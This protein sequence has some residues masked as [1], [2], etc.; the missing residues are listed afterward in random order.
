[1]KSFKQFIVETSKSKEKEDPYYYHITKGS[2]MAGIA[3]KGLVRKPGHRSYSFSKHGSVYLSSTPKSAKSFAP[4]I[5]VSY[6]WRSADAAGW[7]MDAKGNINTTTKTPH[8]LRVIRI[9]KANIDPKKLHRDRNMSFANDRSRKKPTEWE[10]QGDIPAK[11]I[12]F[13]GGE[14][15][16]KKSKKWK[17]ATNDMPDE[18]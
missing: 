16:K 14:H 12:E 6:K 2:S 18:R 9:P 15:L 4:D 1:M 11:N 7:D 13:S 8:S 17:R 10:Y 3:K 5:G